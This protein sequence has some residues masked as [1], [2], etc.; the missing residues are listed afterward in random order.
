RYAAVLLLGGYYS[1]YAL[2][3]AAGLFFF[4]R[5][6]EQRGRMWL[7]IAALP[8]LFLAAV[9]LINETVQ[10]QPSTAARA[11]VAY[12]HAGSTTGLRTSSLEIH[13]CGKRHHAIGVDLVDPLVLL[14]EGSRRYIR[15]WSL[16][17][18]SI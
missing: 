12:F 13:S 7:L 18:E 14:T 9:P 5:R 11:E 1:L 17:M 3:L 2:L 15:H 6:R 8:V 16:A 10:R 4:A